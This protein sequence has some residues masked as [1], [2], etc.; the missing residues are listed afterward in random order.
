[1]SVC[2]CVCVEVSLTVSAGP[3]PWLFLG[4]GPEL[5]T[6]REALETR[7]PPQARR[8]PALPRVPVM[9]PRLV[10]WEPEPAHRLHLNVK[11]EGVLPQHMAIK[12][13]HL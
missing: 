13:C 6:P 7:S 11:G 12:P 5:N 2:T 10:L 3:P 8:H 4:C 9:E 1:M